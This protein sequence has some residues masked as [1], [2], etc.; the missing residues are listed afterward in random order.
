MNEQAEVQEVAGAES[1]ETWSSVL[2]KARRLAK[3][4]VESEK[5]NAKYNIEMYARS[6]AREVEREAKA[7][8]ECAKKAELWAECVTKL[9]A[10]G[11]TPDEGWRFNLKLLVDQKQLKLVYR[12]VGRLDGKQQEKD[13]ENGEEGTVRVTLPSIKYPFLKVSYVRKL[14]A[15]D[16]CKIVT[17]EVPA[18]TEHRL[19]CGV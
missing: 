14:T 6:L 2:N 15:A 1:Q 3:D 17:E 8:E 13:V 18:R 11:L 9:N 19:V 4:A 7:E 10:A 16:K 12:A 5:R